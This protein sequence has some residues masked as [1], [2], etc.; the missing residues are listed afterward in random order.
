MAHLDSKHSLHVNLSN[1]QPNDTGGTG[2]RYVNILSRYAV[3]G[4]TTVTF[5]L[6][7]IQNDIYNNQGSG[8]RGIEVNFGDYTSSPIFYSAEFNSDSET[9]ILP[10]TAIDHTY[11]SPTSSLSALSAT[12]TIFYQQISAFD[13]SGASPVGGPLSAYH[14][15]EFLTTADNIVDRNITL[16]NSQMFTHEGEPVPMFNIETDENIIYPLTYFK[17]LTSEREFLGIYL[18]TDEELT[19]SGIP[20]PFYSDTRFFV[21]SALSAHGSIALSWGGFTVQGRTGRQFTYMFN[22][23]GDGTSI[24]GF[25]STAISAYHEIYIPYVDLS[26]GNVLAMRTVLS[27]ISASIFDTG[28]VGVNKEF[29]SL[30]VTPFHNNGGKIQFN[31]SNLLPPAATEYLHP[32]VIRQGEAESL[33]YGDWYYRTMGVIDRIYTYPASGYGLSASN[34]ITTDPNGDNI[35]AI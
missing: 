1:F 25:S 20:D 30:E 11:Y 27:S 22:I 35:T 21:S 28:V 19:V 3:Q 18:N 7:D 2:S 23:T 17:I 10:F 5:V 32:T 31:H 14:R 26:R 34:R 9:L 15:I 6:S 24:T 8:V 29:N 4:N 33:A 16:L 13:D 12:F